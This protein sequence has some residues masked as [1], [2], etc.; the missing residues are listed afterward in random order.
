M[1]PEETWKQLGKPTLW[2]STFNLVGADQHGIK[3]F[4]TLMAQQVT[5]GTQPLLD[6]VV[7]PLKKKGYDAIVGRGWLVTVKVNQNWQR[8]TLSMEKGGWKYVID[9]RTQMVSEE[10]ASSSESESEGEATGVDE[11]KEGM[12]PNSEGVFELNGCSEDDMCSLNSV[13][14]WRTMSYSNATCSK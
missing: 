7:I 1:L 2:P 14:R 5:T 9:L 12:E 13:G 10:L 8:N 4:G 6:F 11:G 3:P